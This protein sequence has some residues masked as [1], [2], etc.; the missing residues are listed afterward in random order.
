MPQSPSPITDADR[1][2]IAAALHNLNEL[3]LEIDKAKA[4]NHPDVDEYQARCDHC[5]ARL[6][7][8]QE[9]Y[10]Q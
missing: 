8:Y 4:V 3:Q 9:Q 6:Q 10:G 1:R 5:R 2:K 7:A